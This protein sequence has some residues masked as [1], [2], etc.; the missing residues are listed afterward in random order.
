MYKEQSPSSRVVWYAV[1]TRPRWEKKVAALL[2]SRGVTY[3][4]PL[5]RVQRQ[6][7][8]RKKIIQEPLFKGYV[9]VQLEEAKK[10]EVLQVN[11]IINFVHW[12]GK[13]APIREDEIITIR[14]FLQEFT[15]ITVT[16][17]V[18]HPSAKV[19]V[20]QGILMNYEG[21]LLEVS[22]NKAR[23]KIE[24][25]GLQLSAVFNKKDLELISPV[26]ENRK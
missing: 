12:M 22:G 19:K 6:W 24:S 23:V 11:G 21:I 20:K 8:D 9:F 15:D 25:M 4:C 26:V 18:L 1:Y 3:Y 17:T 5:N 14:K 13:P 7:S 2:E 16:E 10:W